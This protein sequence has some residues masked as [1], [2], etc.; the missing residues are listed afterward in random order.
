M[1][2]LPRQ[3]KFFRYRSWPRIMSYRLREKYFKL[4]FF[5][6]KNVFLNIIETYAFD[7]CNEQDQFMTEEVTIS[8][9][10]MCDN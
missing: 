8:Y 6:K 3:R 4:D 1:I 10:N 5:L 9:T 7:Q 2:S